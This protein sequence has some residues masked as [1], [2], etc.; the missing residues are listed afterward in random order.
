MR[1][2]IGWL[3]F[4]AILEVLFALASVVLLGS[5]LGDHIGM[6]KFAVPAAVLDVFAIGFLINVIRQ[7]V[8][9]RQIDFGGPI[10][11]MQKKLETLRVLRIR[12]TQGLL[13]IAVLAWPP[14]CIVLFKAF[15]GLDAYELFGWTYIWVNVLVGLAVIPL[16]IWAAKKIGDRTSGSPAVQ[17]IVRTISGSSLNAAADSL[18]KL[19]EFETE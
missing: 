15:F 2:A 11:A 13:V 17:Y 12:Y 14:L 8:V 4:S 3:T 7:V 18:A 10:A 1:S 5:F 6:P 19:S 16:A 9:A